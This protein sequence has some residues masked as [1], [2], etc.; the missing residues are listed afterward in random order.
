MPRRKHLPVSH[1][2]IEEKNMI[3][4]MIIIIIIIII[5]LS[6]YIALI[7]ISKRFQTWRLLPRGGGGGGGTLKFSDRLEFCRP[8]FFTSIDYM[9]V[10]PPPQTSNSGYAPDYYSGCNINIYI[11]IA[12]VSTPVDAQGA[13]KKYY[14][15][16]LSS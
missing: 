3:T 4:I 5:I 10:P 8:L 11:Y 16:A 14:N 9:Y 6:F 12:H 13:D 2:L 7:R 15:P 1:I